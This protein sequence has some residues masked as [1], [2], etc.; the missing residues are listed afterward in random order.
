MG[1]AIC[2]IVMVMCNQA[3]GSESMG[4][5][6]LRIT[7]EDIPN[8]GI[9]FVDHEAQGRS[10]HGH[11]SLT[12]CKNGDILA[13]YANTGGEGI[14]GHGVAGWS[15]YKRSTDGGKTWSEPMVFEYS[16]RVWEGEELYSAMVF[17]LDTAPDGTLVATVLRYSGRGWHVELPPIYLLS[18]DHGHTWT[19]PR[20]FD[21]SLAKDQMARTY[22]TSFIHQDEL[23]I[24]FWG[25]AGNMNVGPYT[26]WVSDD[27][28]ETFRKRSELP[29]DQWNFYGAA[30]VLPDGRIIVYSYPHRRGGE[31]D[32]H[33]LHYVIS[34]DDG[35][36]WSE[37]KTTH[38]AKRLR[39]PQMSE[40]LGG[41]YYMHGR[42]GHAGDAPRHL[43]LY[44]SE[45][46]INWDEGV[47]LNKGSTTDLDS[48]SANTVVGKFDPATP[49][50]L[51]ILSSIAYDETGRMVNIHQW[52]I[53]IDDR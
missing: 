22:N 53:D 3:V 10:G 23:F 37:V 33:N 12:Q 19:E 49:N 13:F 35:H 32:E 20:E 9:L 43:V 41:L 29:F 39:N 11:S 21:A 15:E 48:Y 42:S 16:K 36:T 34:E 38:F 8:Q 1:W 26:L 51:L 6:A 2:V 4:M 17:S 5:K 24:V 18:H 30:A 52:W 40:R 50:R 27:N 45:D 47:F 25:D 7:P 44:T 14:G 31:T 46:G 28:G